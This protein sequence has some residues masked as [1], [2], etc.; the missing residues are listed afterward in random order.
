MVKPGLLA[1]LSPIAV[2]LLFRLTAPL[3]VGDNCEAARQLVPTALTAF[4]VFSTLTCILF[5]LF[6]NNAGGAWDN[7]KKLVETG[8][9]GGKNS[10]A[11]DASITGD[12]VGDREL[13]VSF[14]FLLLRSFSSFLSSQ[15]SEN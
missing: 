8:F 2:G 7:A 13:V 14:F 12:T 6:F 1:V 4:V 10:S 9:G 11:H 3:A 15:L 5:A